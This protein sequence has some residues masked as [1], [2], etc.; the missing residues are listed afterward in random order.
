MPLLENSSAAHQRPSTGCEDACAWRRSSRPEY[1]CS[2][3]GASKASCSR[4][5]ATDRRNAARAVPG[6]SAQ[7]RAQR[8]APRQSGPHQTRPQLHGGG[9]TGGAVPQWAWQSLGGKAQGGTTNRCRGEQTRKRQNMGMLI[10]C[11][12]FSNKDPNHHAVSSSRPEGCCRR[13]Y[14]VSSAVQLYNV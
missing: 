2:A 5:R 12:P 10:N 13:L 14:T 6:S 4:D 3:E 1:T 7:G 8:T 11:C 9:R